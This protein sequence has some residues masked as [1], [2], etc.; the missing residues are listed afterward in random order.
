M[1]PALPVDAAVDLAA[2]DDAAA[3]A[4][5][6]L[7]AEEV[8]RP[9]G[10]RPACCSPMRHEVHVV[11]DHDGAAQFLAER[12]ADGEPVPA[13]HDRRGDRHALGEAHRPRHPDAGAV[14]ALGDVRRPS[15]WRPWSRTCSKTATGPSRTSIGLV[16]VAE[17]LQLGVGDGDVDRGGADVD[18]EEAQARG[19]PD[20]VR[21]PAAA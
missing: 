3:D 18:A 1:S 20:V 16:E 8:A 2:D 5:A 12:L 15:V 13:R 9:S 21:T 11:V 14:E 19:E 4:G 10:R 17:D 6:D 7:D